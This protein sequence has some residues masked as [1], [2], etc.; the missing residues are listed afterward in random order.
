MNEDRI[1]MSQRERDRLKVLSRVSEGRRSQVEAARLLKLSTR[2]VRRLQR[3]LAKEGDPGIVHRLRGRSSNHRRPEVFRKRAVT[4][5]RREMPD[6][7]A[8]LASEK[9][10]Q[11]GLSVPVGTLRDWLRAEGLLQ[12]RRRR[13]QH[14]HRRERRPCCGELVQADGSHHD[15]LEGRGPWMVLVAFIDDATSKLSARFYPAE[16]TEAYMDLLGSYLRKQGRMVS[17]YVDRDSIFRAEDHHPSDPQP[18]LTQFSRA[19]QELQIELI[20]AYSP[21][22]KGRI[23]RFFQTAQDRLVKELRLAG[24]ATREQANAVLEE[25]FLPWFNRWR[26]VR[27]ASPNNAH[28]PLHPSMNLEAILSIQVRRKVCNDYTI[29]LD[30]QFYQILPPAV[31][32]LRGGRVLIEKRLDGTLRLRLKKQYLPYHW[33]GPSD[34][35]G[36]LPPSPRSSP[37]GQTPAEVQEEGPAVAAAGPSAV[38]LALGRSGRTPAEPCPPKSKTTVPEAQGKRPRT[39]SKWMDNFRFSK[40]CPKTGHSY[41]PQTADTSIRA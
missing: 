36:A 24:A 33:I 17:L 20:L 23:E 1:A 35:L 2:Q 16:T 30:N 41:P 40:R 9:L 39:R 12:P 34:R 28:R 7:G 22:A 6:F 18:T 4:I 3:R 38:R 19:L 31:P 32:G 8:L 27:P 14:R 26:S 37:L 15:W 5:F 29:R 11:R 13:D 10:R 25:T 21:Q